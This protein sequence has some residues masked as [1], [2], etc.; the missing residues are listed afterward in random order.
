MNHKDWDASWKESQKEPYQL[1]NLF[2]RD[3]ELPGELPLSSMRPIIELQAKAGPEAEVNEAQLA[4]IMMD[5]IPLAILNE[6]TQL[7]MT[8]PQFNEV[9]LDYMSYLTG[10][11]LVSQGEAQAP[12]DGAASQV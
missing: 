2:G 10:Q 6:W 3:W 8:T 11:D 5:I 12:A 9:I 7:G 1:L 4:L